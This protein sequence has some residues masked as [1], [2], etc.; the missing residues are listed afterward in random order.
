[1]AELATCLRN[2]TLY[3]P[4]PSIP[5]HAYNYIRIEDHKEWLDK[6]LHG[7]L[8]HDIR[9]TDVAAA[10]FQMRKCQCPACEE[11]GDRLWDGEADAWFRFGDRICPECRA[12]ATALHPADGARRDVQDPPGTE[13]V[14]THNGRVKFDL[15]RWLW[16]YVAAQPY[17]H[18]C[19]HHEAGFYQCTI[20][21]K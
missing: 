18:S 8:A 1:M 11:L 4:N 15:A 6:Q 20:E 12:K 7:I 9:V 16:V 21:L 5:P 13:F 14:P 10:R 3:D 2:L 19:P 17:Y